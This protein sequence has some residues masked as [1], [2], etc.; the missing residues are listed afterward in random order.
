MRQLPGKMQAAAPKGCNQFQPY[1]QAGQSLEQYMS[2]LNQD[3]F[4]PPNVFSFFIPGHVETM[5]TTSAYVGQTATFTQLLE[6]SPPQS[7]TC[8]TGADAWIDVPTLLKLVGSSNGLPIANYLLDALVDGGSPRL[9]S[10]VIGYLGNHPSNANVQGA[11]WL[12]LNSPEYAV[13]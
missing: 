5:M 13:N 8:T 11:I 4:F 3:I 7:S 10:V 6:N 9:R 12:I 2:A 1:Q